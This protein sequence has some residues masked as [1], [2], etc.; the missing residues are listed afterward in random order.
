MRETHWFGEREFAV[1]IGLGQVTP[2]P[3]MAVATFIGYRAAGL[4][5]ALAA[6]LG[7][8]LFPWGSAS[9]MAR[10]LDRLPR[11]ISRMCCAAGHQFQHGP[12]NHQVVLL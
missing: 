8:F 6:T 5:G 4:A 3:V 11:Q 7:V 1:T 2:G 10:H 9:A 12:L